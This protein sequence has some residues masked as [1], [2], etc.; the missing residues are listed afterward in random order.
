MLQVSAQGKNYQAIADHFALSVKTVRSYIS[1][2]FANLQLADRA[3][4]IV[5][6]RDAGI[7][8]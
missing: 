6:A 3:Q 2:N 5:K 4:V 7:G 1:T 8:G